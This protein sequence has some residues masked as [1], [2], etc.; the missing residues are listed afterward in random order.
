MSAPEV[1]PVHLV[2]CCYCVRLC[3]AAEMSDLRQ[4][5]A[6]ERCAEDRE[7][8]LAIADELNDPGVRMTVEDMDALSRVRGERHARAADLPWPPAT[9]DYDRWWEVEH[10]SRPRV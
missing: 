1:E 4:G 10:S 3:P 6:C 2:S 5:W 9:G 7:A 8:W